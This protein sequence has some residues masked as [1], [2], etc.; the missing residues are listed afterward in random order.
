MI[1]G[2]KLLSS[3]FKKTNTELIVTDSPD[4]SYIYDLSLLSMIANDTRKLTL[5]IDDDFDQF[6]KN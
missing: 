1:E 6:L 2:I 5:K 4:D 3:E